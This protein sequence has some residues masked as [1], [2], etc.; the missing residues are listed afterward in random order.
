MQQM[1]FITSTGRPTVKFRA[2]MVTQGLAAHSRGHVECLARCPH[3]V[4]PRDGASTLCF[5]IFPHTARQSGVR[6]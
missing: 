6:C 2:G 3:S 1:A 5:M 4:Y